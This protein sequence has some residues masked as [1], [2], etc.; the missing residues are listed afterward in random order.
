MNA[1]PIRFLLAED[2]DDHAELIMDSMRDNR[3]LNDIMRVSDGQEALDFLRHEGAH[4][5]APRPDV[6]MLDLKM[7]RVDGHEVLEAMKTDPSLKTIPVVIMTTSRA[8]ADRARAYEAHANSYI[9]KPLDF[10]SL[11]EMVRTLGFYWTACNE[12]PPRP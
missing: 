2:D 4:V 5:D 1:E 6:V 7:P 12:S 8:E 3:V 9:V 11:H 10:D